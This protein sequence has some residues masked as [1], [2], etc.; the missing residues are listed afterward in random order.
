MI[1][2]LK[3][4][5]VNPMIR[6]LRFLPYAL[7]G[8]AVFALNA[9]PETH[10]YLQIYITLLEAKLGIVLIYLLSKKLEKTSKVKHFTD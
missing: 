8:I 5:T 9:S 10:P 4:L 6:K 1:S 7:V 3:N 2:G